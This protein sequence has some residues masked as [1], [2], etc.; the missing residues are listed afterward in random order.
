MNIK[1]LSLG[2]LPALELDG[3]DFYKLVLQ[4][5]TQCM[6]LGLLKV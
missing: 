1:C 3:D 5:L 4:E 2:K 6:T